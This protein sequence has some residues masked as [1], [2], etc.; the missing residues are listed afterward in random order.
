MRLRSIALCLVACVKL[1]GCGS[2]DYETTES[3][4][5]QLRHRVYKDG[6][7]QRAIQIEYMTK[8]DI[9]K[10]GAVVDALRPAVEAELLRVFDSARPIV[11][12]HAVDVVY[13]DAQ[14]EIEK[15]AAHRRVRTISAEF[16]YD[17]GKWTRIKPQP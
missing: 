8:V 14:Y 10:N 16:R 5:Y 7:G 9:Y 2:S 12:R 11:Q 15:S 17:A 3:G 4:G 13:L 1:A 6:R